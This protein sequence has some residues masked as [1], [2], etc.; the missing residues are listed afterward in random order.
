MN[1]KVRDRALGM[2]I[3]V[4]FG[5]LASAMLRLE[6]IGADEADILA[7]LFNS[8]STAAL[9]ALFAS[10]STVLY[11]IPILLSAA[12]CFGR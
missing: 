2:L 6:D 5:W 3:N 8:W 10:V 12:F 9:E 1:Y 4:A 11:L 7:G